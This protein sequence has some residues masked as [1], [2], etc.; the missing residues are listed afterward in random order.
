MNDK[1]I[2]CMLINIKVIFYKLIL[3]FLVSVTKHAQSTQNKFG[4]LC[5]IS[6]KVWGIKLIFC[7]QINIKIFYKMVA[8]F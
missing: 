7:L 5:N 6:I 3:S 2:F 1:F 4:Y 8:S